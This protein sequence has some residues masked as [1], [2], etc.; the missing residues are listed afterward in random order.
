[1]MDLPDPST[2]RKNAVLIKNSVPQL[3][4]PEIDEDLVNMEDV[5]TA[6]DEEQVETFEEWLGEEIEN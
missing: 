6:Q 5:E 1:M 4:E 2:L 3:S